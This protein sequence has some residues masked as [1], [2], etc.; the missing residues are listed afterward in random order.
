MPTIVIEKHLRCIG[1][2]SK[3]S[4]RCIHHEDINL[5]K[6]GLSLA[7]Q[8]VEIREIGYIPSYRMTIF[9]QLSNSIV[10]RIATSTKDH[11]PG[12]VVNKLLR[13]RQSDTAASTGN[14]GNFVG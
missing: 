12:T 1:N 6:F 13:R 14:Y 7:E 2:R 4:L 3:F 10:Q 8:S 11:N 9:S 5:A